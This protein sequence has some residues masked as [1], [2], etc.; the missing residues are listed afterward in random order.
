MEF[1]ILNRGQVLTIAKD[2]TEPH[3]ALSVRE[4]NRPQAAYPANDSRIAVRRFVFTDEDCAATAERNG[5]TH[6]LMTDEQAEDLVKFVHEFKDSI[7]LVVCQCDGGLS[8]SAGMAAALSVIYNGPGS[9]SHIFTK[10]IPNRYVYRK[11]LEANERLYG[12]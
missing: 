1:M 3:V 10:K 2:I 6:L 5:Q 12:E 8:R 7:A 9:D 11:I 4:P